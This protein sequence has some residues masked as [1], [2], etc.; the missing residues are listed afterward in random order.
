MTSPIL[1]STFNFDNRSQRWRDSTTGRFVSSD[2]VNAE[3]FRHS[4]AT[5]ATLEGLTRQ[6]YAG[7]INLARWQV[8]VASELKDAHLAQA[9]FAV[10]GR[11]NMGFAEFGRVGQTLREQYGYLNTFAEQIAR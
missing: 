10:G 11:D 4:D 8:A 5:H 3:M 6:L 1:D 2:A 9:M 7:D